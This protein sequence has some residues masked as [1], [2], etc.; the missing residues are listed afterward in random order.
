[1]PLAPGRVGYRSEKIVDHHRGDNL[2][3]TTISC[4]VYCLF[5]LMLV[6]VRFH[7]L[8]HS[9]LLLP[10]CF[11]KVSRLSIHLEKYLLLFLLHRHCRYQQAANL[12]RAMCWVWAN[13][14]GRWPARWGWDSVDFYTV[15]NLQCRLWWGWCWC[16]HALFL[17]QNW[18]VRRLGNPYTVKPLSL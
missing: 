15:F 2:R 10:H 3:A 9:F 8:K 11:R 1:M 6:W 16:S 18:S 7:N 4:W 17:Q 14:L 5:V 12:A 13:R